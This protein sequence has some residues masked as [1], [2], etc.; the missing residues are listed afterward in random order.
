M[1]FYPLDPSHARILI[2]S[3]ELGCASEIIDILSLINSGPVWIDRASDRENAAQARLK[4]LNQDGDHL[5]ALNVFRAYL[6][7]R[8]QNQGMGKWCKDNH[9]NKR[10]LDA[11][12]K[13]RTQLIELAI[14]DGRRPE[15]TC[16]TETS[17]VIRALLRGLFMNTAVVQADGTYRQTAGSLVSLLPCSSAHY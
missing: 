9:V 13:I 17:L 3:F 10:T 6:A 2:A 7:I 12:L 8:D 11:A 4:H 15:V 1:L 14:R 16:G 5:T